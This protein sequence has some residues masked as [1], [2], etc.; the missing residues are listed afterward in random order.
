MQRAVCR[1]GA[2]VHDC[3]VFPIRAQVGAR[4]LFLV[5]SGHI[6]RL[7]VLP[8]NRFQAPAVQP[9]ARNLTCGLV[10]NPATP[11]PAACLQHWLQLLLEVRQRAAVSQRIGQ[12]VADVGQ[13]VEFGDAGN[14]KR[15]RVRLGPDVLPTEPD[16]KALLLK[17]FDCLGWRQADGVGQVDVSLGHSPGPIH[18]R[19]T[20]RAPGSR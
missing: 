6:G 12:P 17:V 14:G 18:Q 19:R 16:G 10:D 5:A 3:H 11:P 8:E 2:A 20:G 15:L 7:H 13:D 1:P 9:F 4:Q